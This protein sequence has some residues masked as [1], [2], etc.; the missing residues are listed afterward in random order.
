MKK[1]TLWIA[2]VAICVVAL[3]AH[4]GVQDQAESADISGPAPTIESPAEV[5]MNPVPESDAISE[6]QIVPLAPICR[7]IYNVSPASACTYSLCESYSCGAPAYYDAG[8]NHC[9]CGYMY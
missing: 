9:A 6:P 2:F 7:I 1:M 8:C 5:E 4:A 3:G